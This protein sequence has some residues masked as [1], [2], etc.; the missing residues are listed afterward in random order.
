MMQIECSALA[1][2]VIM[3]ENCPAGD[4]VQRLRADKPAVTP[5]FTCNVQM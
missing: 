1:G 3:G 2:G 4:L 5:A